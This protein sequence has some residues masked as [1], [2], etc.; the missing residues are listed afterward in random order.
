M[1]IK[2]DSYYMR[3][4]FRLAQIVK[5]R[6]FPNPAVGAVVVKNGLI[7]GKGATQKAGGHHAEKM[8][9][10]DAGDQSRGAT[11]YVTLEPCCHF[12]RTPPCT[13]AIIAAGISRVVVTQLDPNPLVAGK[14]VKQLLD[15][16][17]EVLT[18][19]LENETCRLNEDFFWSIQ[20]SKAWITLKLAMTLDGRIADSSSSSKWITCEKSRKF[21]HEL[22]RMHAAVGVGWSTLDKD[23]PQL[24]VRHKL[25]YNPARII[26]SHDMQI[27]K[28]S[29]FYKNA[30]DTRSI[31]VVRGGNRNII[32]DPV[33]GI[34]FWNTGETGR[35]ANLQVFQEIAFNEGLTSVFIEGGQKLA[36]EFLGAAIVNRIYFFY[37]N[38][39]LGNGKEGILLSKPVSLKECMT[40]EKIETRRFDEDVMVSGIPR[41]LSD[42]K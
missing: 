13:D 25:G 41:F 29:Y 2:S 38:R 4:A 27:P 23:D 21:V 37:G 35:E 22:R 34:E 1:N 5:G 24:T 17:I 19:L 12:G 6:T 15:A 7:I 31:V 40:L 20:N 42:C 18:G 16:G 10:S 32:K 9:L 28:T 33:S 36:S 26:F 3:C 8:A 11:L 39:I 14:G 30:L